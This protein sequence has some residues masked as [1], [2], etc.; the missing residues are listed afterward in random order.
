ML[1]KMIKAFTIKWYKSGIFHETTKELKKKVH[2][3][4]FYIII[5]FMKQIGEMQDKVKWFVLLKNINAIFVYY[6][7]RLFQL[8]FF[9]IPFHDT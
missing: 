4:F 6:L 9:W 5:L 3:L 8:F 2:T 7:S 1:Y